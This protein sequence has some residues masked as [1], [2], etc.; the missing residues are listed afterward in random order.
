MG[1][2]RQQQR[3]RIRLMIRKMGLCPQQVQREG[4]KL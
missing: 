1:S 3:E 2:F 4:R